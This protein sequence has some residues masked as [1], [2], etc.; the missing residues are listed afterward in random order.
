M[1]SHSV[2]CHPTRVNIPC[3]N[4]SQPGW[5][6]IYLPWRHRRLSWPRWSVAYWDGLSSHR[7]SPIQVVTWQ[8]NGQQSNSQPVN[9]KSDTLT[10]TLPNHFGVLFSYSWC[11]IWVCLVTSTVSEVSLSVFYRVV[12]KKLATKRVRLLLSEVTLHKL[13]YWRC[14]KTLK[15]SLKVL[16]CEC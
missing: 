11:T 3:L 4:H 16:C 5:Y 10:T 9:Y 14:H 13:N 6:S 7:R 8:W 12:C 1:G 2:T 15:R